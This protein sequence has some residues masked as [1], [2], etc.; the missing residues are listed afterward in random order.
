MPQATTNPGKTLLDPRDHILVMIDYQ[1]QLAFTTASIDGVQ[2][3]NNAALVAAAARAFSV[4][5]ILTTISAKSFSGPLFDEIRSTLPDLT[6]FDRTTMNC[7][8]DDSVIAEINRLGK[9]RIVMSGLWTSVCVAGPTLSALDQDFDV[10]VI[11]DACGDT[12]AEAHR[13]AIER[14]LQI[15]ARPLTALQYLLELQRDW[16]R[17]ETAAKTT[18]AVLAHGGI[19]GL[20]VVY[21]AKMTNGNDPT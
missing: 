9:K 19:Y 20:G 8:E 13:S 6:I 18:G 10:Y 21:A 5:T 16:A 1:P 3:R 17:T 14:M 7:W 12:S 2:L 4:P 11:T 15:G